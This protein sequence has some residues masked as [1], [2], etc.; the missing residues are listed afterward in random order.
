MPL[1]PPQL[2]PL[3]GTACVA[4]AMA[5]AVAVAGCAPRLSDDM[6][7]L[8]ELD[9]R[10][11]ALIEQD[12]ERVPTGGSTAQLAQPHFVYLQG[13]LVD[14]NRARWYWIAGAPLEPPAPPAST[15]PPVPLPAP[16]T[17]TIPPEASP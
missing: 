7:R 11:R 4:L 6:F 17:T 10:D 3:L 1:P 5:M 15:A 8:D 12:R 16:A 14:T 13:A 9:P 2:P